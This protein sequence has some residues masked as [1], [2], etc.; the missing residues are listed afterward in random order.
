MTFYLEVMWHYVL[1]GAPESEWDAP[2]VD[3]TVAVPFL[4][5]LAEA[6]AEQRVVRKANADAEELA[7]D[8]LDHLE[9][10]GPELRH[11]MANGGGGRGEP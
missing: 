7:K 6:R 8:L 1:H 2:I 11:V 10:Q 9:E 3:P 4:S 5:H